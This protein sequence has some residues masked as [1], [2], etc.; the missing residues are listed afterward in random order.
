MPV[1]GQASE[2]INAIFGVKVNDFTTVTK[3]QAGKLAFAKVDAVEDARPARFEEVEP[4]V[5]QAM[6]VKKSEEIA[7]AKVKEAAAKLS[8]GE[9]FNSVAKF[10]GTEAK[11]SSEIG[12]DGAIEGVGDANAFSDLFSKPVG[13]VVGPVSLMGQFVVAKSIGKVEPSA[14]LYP[15]DALLVSWKPLKKKM[16]NERYMLFKDSVMQHLL[17]K[18]ARS[19]AIRKRH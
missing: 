8:A 19:S 7:Q 12:R 15:H 4:Q 3:P 16:A 1:F 5:R 13:S 14:D 10:L 11:A 2:L 9:D 17:A 6:R 18:R